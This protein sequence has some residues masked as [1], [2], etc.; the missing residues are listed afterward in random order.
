MLLLRLLQREAERRRDKAQGS[1]VGPH[2]G[3]GQ[4]ARQVWL[5]PQGQAGLGTT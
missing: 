1:T 5:A 4:Q 2:Q 3:S